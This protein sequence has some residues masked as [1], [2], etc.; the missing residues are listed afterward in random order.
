MSESTAVAATG[1]TRS[2]AGN[3]GASRPGGRSV[4]KLLLVAALLVVLL[5]LPIYVPE[6]WL[7]TGFAVF[8]AI[9]GA[10][11][12]NLLVGTTGQLSLAHAFFLAVG[13]V[14]YAFVSGEPGGLGVADLDGPSAAVNRLQ[15]LGLRIGQRIR[16]LQPGP[17]HLVQVGETRLCL[18]AE[19]D[20]L[21]LIGLD[22]G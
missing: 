8:A 16:M 3:G 2:S 11:G 14:S 13:A 1:A 6:F 7:R 12:L 10:I 21:V 18:R 5:A 4:I 20:V 22:E 19:A 15:E 17:P 9:V